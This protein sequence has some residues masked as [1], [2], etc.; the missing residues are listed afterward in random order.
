MLGMRLVFGQR[1]TARMALGS[2]FAIIGITLVFLPELGRLARDRG[3]EQGALFTVLALLISAIGGLIAYR[4]H[5]RK[6]HGWPTMA[7]SMGYGGLAALAIAL[8]LGRPIAIE[9]SP[10]YLLSLLYLAVLGS[11]VAFGGWL[12]LLGRVGPASAS[13]VGV[14]VPIVAL[15]ISALFEGLPWHPLTIAG[16]AISVTGNVLVLRNA[17]R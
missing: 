9:W 3:V 15:I 12:T 16:M 5:E 2:A 14:M 7:W 1:M 6:L 4:N 10:A 8:A 11:V 13:Y 17:P